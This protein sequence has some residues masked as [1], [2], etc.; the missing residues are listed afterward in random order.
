MMAAILRRHSPHVAIK[1][2]LLAAAH[3]LQ[4][5][6]AVPESISSKLFAPEAVLQNVNIKPTV[7]KL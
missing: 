6:S 2:G 7:L 4:S 5:F 1:A 3:S